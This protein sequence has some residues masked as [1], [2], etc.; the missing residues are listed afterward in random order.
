MDEE[1]E[2]VIEEP[3]KRPPRK[4]MVDVRVIQ[5]KAGSS[6]VQ[7]LDNK[8]L[9][10]RG[11]LPTDSIENGMADLN[12]LDKAIPFGLPW[13][14]YIKVIATPESIANELRRRGVWTMGDLSNISAVI[15]ANQAFALG[16]F[17]ATAK[18][19]SK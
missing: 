12:E 8:G 7:W 9:H 5:A 2:S 15:K 10:H 19:A 1:K 11:F 13:E 14:D 18:E 16:D 3:V 17:M 6:L 4:R